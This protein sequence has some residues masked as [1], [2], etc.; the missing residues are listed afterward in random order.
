MEA[1]LARFL[2]IYDNELYGLKW[3]VSEKI[4]GAN[5]SFLFSPNAPVKYF[6]RNQEIGGSD[7]DRP[8]SFYGSYELMEETRKRMGWI[9]NY[10]DNN[11]V[12]ARTYGEL[13]GASVQKGVDYGN[14]KRILFYDILINDKQQTVAWFEGFMKKMGIEDLMGPVFGLFGT[15]ADALAFNTEIDSVLL[16]VEPREDQ[17]MIE[18]VVIKPY[19]KVLEDCNSSLFYIKKK[20]DK[21]KEAQSVKKAKT[22]TQYTEEVNDWRDIFL[23]YLHTERLESVFSK[24]GR[25]ASMKEIG[26]FIKLVGEDTRETFLKEEPDYPVEKLTKKERSYIM[27]ASREIAKLLKQEFMKG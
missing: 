7:C 1:D 2:R 12:T 4:H 21:F 25:I 11:G 13:F 8:V 20:N 23:S 24:E 16:P 9:Q 3:H 22:V 19:D 14:V 15:L 10:V 5:I 27:N 17:R 18:G 26:K 6:S